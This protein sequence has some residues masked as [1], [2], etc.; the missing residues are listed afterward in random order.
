MMRNT[1]RTFVGTVV[2]RLA[3]PAAVGL[4]PAVEAGLAALPG[5]GSVGVDE[6]AGLLVVTAREPVERAEVLALLDG[7]GCRVAG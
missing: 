5:I 2:F 7:L 1:P 4:G 3:A 6:A